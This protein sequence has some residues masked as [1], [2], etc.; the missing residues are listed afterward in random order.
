[1]RKERHRRAEWRNWRE[2]YRS[3][4]PSVTCQGCDTH[5]PRGKDEGNAI[6]NG[7][8]LVECGKCQDVIF[9]AEEQRKA[10][11]RKVVERIHRKLAT[12]IAN[13]K[14]G[15]ASEPE[16]LFPH[17]YR[18]VFRDTACRYIRRFGGQTFSVQTAI[19]DCEIYLRNRHGLTIATVSLLNR[20]PEKVDT[21]IF[22]D[23]PF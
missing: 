1:M 17:V 13:R 7:S 14:P 8:T 15:P 5:Y 21:A 12:H 3:S 4:R 11:V 22:D 19:D 18:R 6:Y 2:D 16:I 23:M 10:E 20:F 9:H